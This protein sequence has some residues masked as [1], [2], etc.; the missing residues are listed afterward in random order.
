[1][2][3]VA[4]LVASVI[5]STVLSGSAAVYKTFETITVADTAIGLTATTHTPLGR[6][7]MTTCSITNETAE[8]RIRW[9]GVGPTAAVGKPIQALDIFVIVT[10]EDIS[11]LRMIRTTATSATA[12]VTCWAN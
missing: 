6:P 3:R 7:Q 5:C 1:M 8:I 11:Q 12:T 4:L 2:R 9:D 10:H